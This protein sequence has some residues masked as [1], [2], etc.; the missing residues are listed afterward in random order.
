VTQDEYDQ[1]IKAINRERS[2]SI[3]DLDM[4]RWGPCPRYKGHFDKISFFCGGAFVLVLV[5]VLMIFGSIIF[6]WQ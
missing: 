2:K 1:R 6:H 5:L 3:S 4:E